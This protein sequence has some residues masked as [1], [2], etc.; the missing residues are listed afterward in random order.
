MRNHKDAA[1]VADKLISLVAGIRSGPAAVSVG[2]SVVI[3]LVDAA[4]PRPF[5]PEELLQ[6]ADH[7]MSEAKR[8]GKG[9]YAFADSPKSAS[10]TGRFSA[11]G[12]LR[13]KRK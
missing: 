5:L 7:A 11:P 1:R 3:V 4:Q 2:V 6:R 12:A 13:T 9:G 8:A 10:V